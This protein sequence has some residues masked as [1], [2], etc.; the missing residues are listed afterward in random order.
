MMHEIKSTGES[1]CDFLVSKCPVEFDKLIQISNHV[2]MTFVSI[3]YFFFGGHF[4]VYVPPK[5][6]T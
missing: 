6:E 5:N 4:E 1:I 3:D 2:E